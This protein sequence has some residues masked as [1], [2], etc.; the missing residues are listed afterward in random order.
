MFAQGPDW[1]AI[2]KRSAI[3]S[4][5]NSFLKEL[6]Q[7]PNGGYTGRTSYLCNRSDPI[8]YP[9]NSSGEWVLVYYRDDA[10]GY[11]KTDIK[12]DD[13]QLFMRFL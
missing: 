1:T 11:Y 6:Q 3:E 9:A 13:I 4:V 12:K 2:P 10:E 5:A 8:G 7:K